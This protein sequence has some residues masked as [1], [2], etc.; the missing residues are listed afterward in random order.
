[1]MEKGPGSIGETLCGD[2]ETFPHLDGRSV[3]IDSEKDETPLCCCCAHGAV[4][5]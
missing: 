4:N 3:V 1:L 5:L 2:G